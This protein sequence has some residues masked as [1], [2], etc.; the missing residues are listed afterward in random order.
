MSYVFPVSK[1]NLR[2]KSRSKKDKNV[3]RTIIEQDSSNDHK[4][5]ICRTYIVS[6]E[7]KT[8][9]VWAGKNWPIQYCCMERS[10]IQTF[11]VPIGHAM[12]LIPSKPTRNS[13]V[14]ICLWSP[15]ILASIGSFDLLGPS[16]EA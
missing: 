15:Q 6:S 1:I 7:E 9:A 5:Y 11:R 13:V 2:K 10:A 8:I 3:L 12:S 4:G 16:C 14:I